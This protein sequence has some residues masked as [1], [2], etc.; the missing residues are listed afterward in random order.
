VDVLDWVFEEYGC[1]LFVVL[2]I[3][4]FDDVFV[5]CIGGWC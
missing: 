3:D 2:F 4:V 5:V 1:L